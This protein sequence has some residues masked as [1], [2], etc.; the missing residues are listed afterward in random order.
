MSI[1]VKICGINSKPAMTAAL[2]A[3]ADYVGLMFYPPSPRYLSVAA[4]AE[5]SRMVPK[6]I[7]R[8]GVFVDA[9]ENVIEETLDDVGLDALQLHGSESVEQ[10]AAIADRFGLPVIRAVKLAA[11]DDLKAAAA[12]EDVA[13][14]LLFD[15]KPP[16]ERTD[17]LP[18]GNALSFD[19]TMLSGY[20]GRRPWFLSG[21]LTAANLAR[22]VAITG[23]AMVDVSSGVETR[24]GAK[25]PALIADF[26]AAAR[27]IERPN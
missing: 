16:P 22:A 9:P 19:W 20:L 13:D 4:A 15:A 8:V 21:G 14:M 5:L 3:G 2:T 10:V 11:P 17:A 1:K 12:F 23:A 25:D 27:A 18:G 7:R 24:P 6:T 26:I